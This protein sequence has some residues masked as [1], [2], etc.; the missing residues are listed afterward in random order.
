M[1]LNSYAHFKKYVGGY[2]R[3]GNFLYRGIGAQFDLVPSIS[4]SLEKDIEILRERASRAQQAFNE[5][6]LELNP[7]HTLSN[8]Q[9][10][11][12]SRHS[13]LIS[14]FIDFSIDDTVAIQFGMEMAKGNPVHLYV[15]NIADDPIHD[16]KSG[17][18]D[19]NGFTVF[20]PNLIWNANGLLTPERTQFIQGA[21]LVSQFS[22]TW[23]TPFDKT[24]SH[25]IIRYEIWPDDFEKF[26]EEIIADGTKMDANLL[27]EKKNSLFDLAS[28]INKEVS[29][30]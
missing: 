12:L 19:S 30:G 17:I 4:Y 20:R 25:K 22:D 9:L 18:I 1:K 10:I 2:P 16:G 24:F 15:L 7:Q 26:Q 5:K 13:G 8:Y 28:E 14:P 11:F 29:K 21:R 6:F 3:N 23:T 27:I